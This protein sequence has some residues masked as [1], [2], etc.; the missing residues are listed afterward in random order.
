MPHE[1]GGR[2]E[3][4]QHILA[5]QTRVFLQDIL[6][7]VT[8]REELKNGA[9]G[10]PGATDGRLAVANIGVDHDAVHA[11]NIVRRDW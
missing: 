10:D 6:D 9:H 4:R 2:G 11:F 1:G 8:G 3:A 7:G 5:G